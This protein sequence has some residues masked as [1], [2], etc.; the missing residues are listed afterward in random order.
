MSSA[1]V[2][3][4]RFVDAAA[5]GLDPVVDEP[6]SWCKPAESSGSWE[7]ES[8]SD[9]EESEDEGADLSC[10]VRTQLASAVA[11]LEA[12]PAGSDAAAMCQAL[13]VHARDARCR[14]ALCALRA[15]ERAIVPAVASLWDWSS[16]APLPPVSA[17]RLAR[18]LCAGA[19]GGQLAVRTCGLLAQCAGGVPALRAL[20]DAEHIAAAR[21][22]TQCMGNA[23]ASNAANQGCVWPVAFAAESGWF[24]RALAADGGWCGDGSVV[25]AVAM[26]IFSCVSADSDAAR[27]RLGALVA[28]GALVGRLAS[29]VCAET[30]VDEHPALEFVMLLCGV[31]TRRGRFVDLLR[32]V[33]RGGAGAR[34][35]AAAGAAAEAG[36]EGDIAEASVA[37]LVLADASGESRAL[38]SVAARA[39]REASLSPALT[40]RTQCAAL[41]GILRRA[42]GDDDGAAP[43]SPAV[44]LAALSILSSAVLATDGDGRHADGSTAA[45]GAALRD[46]L[47]DATGVDGLVRLVHNPRLAAVG[48]ASAVK[49]ALAAAPAASAAEGDD[50]H[51][52]RQAALRLVANLAYRHAGFQNALRQ[53]GGIVEVLGCMHI[54]ARQPVLREWALL[55]LRNLCEGNDANQAAIDALQPLSVAQNPELEKLGLRVEMDGSGKCRVRPVPPK[56]P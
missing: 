35:S 1:A 47:L 24:R 2:D 36:R 56:L 51:A 13:G 9:E 49:A 11:S 42:A 20:R 16:D 34:P 43:H 52:L 33:A 14:A 39:M 29:L 50:A 48:S 53:A 10:D 28:D 23:L 7:T 46:A 26:C 27:T 40:D 44:L 19:G 30:L 15:F 22:L 6:F 12:A 25:N 54:D 37:A 4:Q 17:L 5:A 45:A 3:E 21:A 38:L 55:A 32:A 18:N 41:G 8:G 31:V